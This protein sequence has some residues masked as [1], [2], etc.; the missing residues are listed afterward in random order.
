MHSKVYFL[1]RSLLLTSGVLLVVLI[2]VFLLSFILFVDRAN[3]LD[4]LWGFG[5]KGVI[6]YLSL[7]PWILIII[8]LVLILVIEVA[9]RHLSFAWRRPLIYSAVGVII[10]LASFAGL[11]ARTNLHDVLFKNAAEN[12]LS[13]I[14]GLYRGFGL[15]QFKNIYTGQVSQTSASGFVLIRPD[16]T[17]IQIKYS[18]Q[19]HFPNGPIKNDDEVFVAGRIS[20]QTLEAYGVRKISPNEKIQS[21]RGRMYRWNLRP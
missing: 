14:G 10:L 1:A 15:R 12:R 20:G 3:G 18:N 16:N 6:L 19:T 7:Q 17:Q 8:S 21:G 5:F 11:V 4:W 13:I 2:L 9:I